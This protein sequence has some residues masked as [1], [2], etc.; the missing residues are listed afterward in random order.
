MVPSHSLLEKLVQLVR[1]SLL[2]DKRNEKKS[3]YSHEKEKDK[4]R[5]YSSIHC[6]DSTIH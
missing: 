2:E 1:F 3:Y 6:L 5:M 4:K